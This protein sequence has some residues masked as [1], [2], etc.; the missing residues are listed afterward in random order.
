MVLL[1]NERVLVAGTAASGTPTAATSGR[2]AP[3]RPRPGAVAGGARRPGRGARH[4]RPRVEPRA[5]ARGR[6]AARRT[7]GGRRAVRHQRRPPPRRRPRRGRLAAGAADVAVVV[8][9]YTH[10][11]EGENMPGRGGGDRRVADAARPRT[12]RSSA[13]SAAANPRTVVV[14]VGG[15]AI[16][17]ESWRDAGGR[18][19]HGLVPG[20][21]GRHAPWPASCSA[22][23]PRAAGCPAPG[24]AAPSS[25]RRSI[26]TPGRVRLR[27]AP[28]L[29]ADGGDGPVA[30]LPVRLRPVVH[31]VRARPDGGQAGRGR[32]GAR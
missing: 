29:P 20:H 17:T 9:G 3:A 23:S 21:G 15:S 8:V 26:P 19:A 13:P 12:R 28:R 18:P 7:A 27:P 4:G 30:R 32:V 1:R 16:V 25:C 6:D 11:D 14:L 2:R 5:R 24:P 10:R 22:R 31:H